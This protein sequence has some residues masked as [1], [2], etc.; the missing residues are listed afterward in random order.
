MKVLKTYFMLVAADMARAIVFYKQALG[1]KERFS[2]PD[3]SEL[4]SGGTTIA[5]HGGG[6]PGVTTD[7]GLGFE[8]DDIQ[9][10]C[11]RI[12]EAGGTIVSPPK[13]EPEVDLQ[14]ATV[15]DPEGNRFYVVETG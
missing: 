3:W 11:T 2:S 6:K 8:V 14:K 10:A 9:E 15:A 7:T 12:R 4:D 13:Q 5:L 1:L